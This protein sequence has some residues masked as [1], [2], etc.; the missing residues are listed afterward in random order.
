MHSLRNII[1]RNT[2]SEDKLSPLLPKS[3]KSAKS[4]KSPKSPRS[5]KSL[6]FTERNP[7]Y[8]NQCVGCN[9]VEN[10]I[11]WNIEQRKNHEA[12]K[13]STLLH[14]SFKE[15]EECASQCEI[16]RLF[17]QSLLLEEVTFD[18]V[19]AIEGTEGEV[20]VQWQETT[21]ADGTPGLFL[22][23][24]ITDAPKI[25][26]MINCSSR[27]DIAHLALRGNGR[28]AAVIK[29]AK[30]WLDICRTTHIGIC[31]NLKFDSENPRLLI[32]IVSS[33]TIRLRENLTG[34]CEYVALSYC[35]GNTRSLPPWEQ[36]EVD[37]GKTTTK[38]L[39]DRLRSFA[40]E[41]L[42]TTVRD[43]LYIIHKIGIRYAWIDTLCVFQDTGEGVSTMHK[44]YSNAL[45][46]LCACATTKAT[47]KLLDERKAWK[48]RTEP[49]RLGGQWLT[50]S[51]MSLNSLRLR[52]PLAERA[53]TLQEERLSPRMLYISSSRIYWS[54][55]SGHEMELK[56]TYDQESTEAHRPVYAASGHDF[57]LPTSQEFLLACRRGEG[58][59]D[60]HPYWAD[61]VR[62]YA[63]RNMTNPN[64]RLRALSGL[65]A[66]Y[67]SANN[68][69]KYLAGI[70]ALNLPEG[71][72]WKVNQAV[73][74]DGKENDPKVP[75]WPSWSWAVLPLQTAIE[76]DARSPRTAFF[77]RI[78]DDDMGPLGN[79]AD[80]GAAIREGEEVRDIYVTGRLRPLW[81]PSSSLVEWSSVSKLVGNEERFT[82]ANN[83]ENDV[84]AIDWISGRVLVYENRKR[85]VIGQLDFRH[86]LEKVKSG[87]CEL[88]ALEIG[89]TSM[90]L[91][92]NCGD[93][94][95]RRVGAAWNV[96]KDFFASVKENDVLLLR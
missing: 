19:R 23:V 6:T 30:E 13:P 85:E 37:R 11:R 28:N 25:V 22:G 29:Q 79:I 12:R 32:E 93:G 15:L 59:D 34:H 53:W 21:T 4:P 42:P 75:K 91:L 64:D 80:E 27:N 49:C 92:E 18:G 67:L 94:T 87:E 35:W 66:K 72:A 96:R 48:Y 26:G 31:D 88:V 7:D 77:Q 38:N 14:N 82:F 55:S 81:E 74:S 71:L 90:L 45:F 8:L 84:H 43:A 46:T 5:P 57:Q 39:K 63:L 3:S 52:S 33:E 17:R 62:S 69:D 86:D 41:H 1:P 50:T 44:V 51:D 10:L 2:G 47:A 61:I 95:H 60:L 89:E 16:C 54:C 65:A 36:D 9:K 83:P 20:I 68:R 70:W 78:L 58:A 56:P 73:S 24:R 76:T 40:I